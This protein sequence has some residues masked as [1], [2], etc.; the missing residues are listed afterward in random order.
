MQVID[1]SKVPQELYHTIKEELF[2]DGET[3]ETTM[4]KNKKVSSVVALRNFQI[5]NDGEKFSVVHGKKYKVK[6]LPEGALESFKKD[7]EEV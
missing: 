2:E 5:V 6:E 1:L 3:N 7:F 4:T